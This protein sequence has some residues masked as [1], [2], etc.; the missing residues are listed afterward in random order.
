MDIDC[1]IATCIIQNTLLY[2]VNTGTQEHANCLL[3]LVL[4]KNTL[5]Y[6]VNTGTQ[7]HANCLEEDGFNTWSRFHVPLAYGFDHV[8]TDIKMS[9]L[10]C[11]LSLHT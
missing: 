11:P 3:Q 2:E 1:K 8:Q 10:T 7:E 5:L 6:E 9:Q 4:S